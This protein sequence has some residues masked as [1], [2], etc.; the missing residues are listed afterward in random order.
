MISRLVI[1]TLSILGVAVAFAAGTWAVTGG[2]QTQVSCKPEELKPGYICFG[3]ARKLPGVVWVD[4]RTRELWLKNGYQDS[5]F[6]TDHHT[7]DFSSLMAE[8]FESL[9]VAESVV[10]YCS[11]EGCGSSE[12]VSNKIKELDL[13]PSDR[14]FV[15]AGGWKALEV[16]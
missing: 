14:I 16:E 4:A 9:A 1:E 15:L 11:T 13:I 7:E 8:A 12:P 2:P 6:L 5:V 3:D 10:V